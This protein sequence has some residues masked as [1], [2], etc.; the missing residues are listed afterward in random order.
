MENDRLH[1]KLSQLRIRKGSVS[2]ASPSIPPSSSAGPTSTTPT[3]QYHPHVP[4][5]PQLYPQEP[6]THGIIPPPLPN[7]ELPAN[8]GFY[9]G[10]Y[11]EAMLPGPSNIRF[12]TSNAYGQGQGSGSAVGEE[13]NGSGA[14][15]TGDPNGPRKK[16]TY[17]SDLYETPCMVRR[18]DSM[19]FV[20]L[21]DISFVV[22]ILSIGNFLPFSTQKK[23]YTA[24]QYVCVT[25]GRTDSPEWRKVRKSYSIAL[26]PFITSFFS[27]S[28]C[29]ATVRKLPRIGRGGEVVVQNFLGCSVFIL[30]S[31]FVIF[32]K[33]RARLILIRGF[34]DF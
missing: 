16:V 9:G 31:T 24:E 20:T 1:E 30:F 14:T 11:E 3:S 22:S 2:S 33:P 26:L 15:G 8:S 6:A 19:A 29:V 13:D 32:I 5:Y 4:Q 10:A 28:L 25:C 21:S 34:W 17:L 12:D 27:A 18:T 23:V 7:G